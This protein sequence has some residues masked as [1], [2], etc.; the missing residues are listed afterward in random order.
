[1]FLP[2]RRSIYSAASFSGAVLLAIATVSASI[3]ST[4]EEIIRWRSNDLGITSPLASCQT[5]SHCQVIKGKYP[6][7]YIEL[8]SASS[9]TIAI[10]NNSK[11]SAEPGSYK[12]FKI[13]GGIKSD[14]RLPLTVGYSRVAVGF[15]QKQQPLIEQRLHLHFPAAMENEQRYRLEFSSQSYSEI[16]FIYREAVSSSI[17]VNQVGYLPASRKIAFVGNWLGN[18]GA[19]PVNNDDF[20]LI[21]S[22]NGKPVYR[23]KLVNASTSDPWSGNDVYHADFSEIDKSGS[24]YVRVPGI[25][26]SYIFEIADSVYADVYQK[27]F[28]LFYHS[29]NSTEIR[30]PYSDAGNERPGGIAAKLNGI[31]HTAVK[32]SPFGKTDIPGRYRPVHGGWFDAGDYGQYVVNAAP[33]WYQFSA[34]FDLYPDHL[35]GDDMG[36]PESGNHIPDLI[37][38][39]QWGIT[40]LLGMQ[41][42]NDGGVYSRLTPQKWDEMLPHEA[43][44]TRYFFEKTT[45]ATASFAASLAIHGRLLANIRTQQAREVLNAAESAW[46]FLQNSPQWP[47]EGDVYRNPEGVHAGEYPD[48][49]SLDNRLWAAAE[50]YRATEKKEYLEAFENL[51]RKTSIDPTAPVSFKEQGLAACWAMLMADKEGLAVN[52]E[53]I[54]S[55]RDKLIARADWLL[56]KADENPY[57]APIHQ[58]IGFTGWGSFAQSSRAVLPLMQ[59]YHLTGKATYFEHAKEMTNPQLG[60]N[61]QSISYITGVGKRYPRHPLSKLS[62]FDNVTEPLSG[63][64][65]NGP[66]YHL[67]ELWHS[68]R[69]VNSSYVPGEKAITD[70]D[71][72][73]QFETAYPALRRYVDSSLLPPMSE[74]TIA[75]YAQTVIAYGLLT[76]KPD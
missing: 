39:L 48:K 56:R 20:E 68:T 28:R 70:K 53:I 50:L 22:K 55:L 2:G 25:G 13:T 35:S 74:P 52:P 60:A 61:P 11:F 38:E 31:V 66:H 30:Q 73:L 3:N 15:D 37:D 72:N 46:H 10:A 29:R 43:N 32:S 5:D 40:W 21:D 34:G 69:T 44:S 67:P 45:H 64:P 24:Y 1:M 26:H 75:E 71:G 51:Y 41:D 19:M 62:Q 54:N 9:L 17:Q 12:L 49:S 36:I 4:E 7:L 33:V 14:Y 47:E 6:V 76:M 8:L 18:S 42:K 27:T 57:Y 23:G 63:I 58:Y 16:E 59:A 65:V